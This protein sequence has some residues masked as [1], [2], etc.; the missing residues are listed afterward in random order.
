MLQRLGGKIEKLTITE[1]SRLD[2]EHFLLI[3]KQLKEK[4]L[5]IQSQIE[6]TR[7]LK[8]P[9]EERTKLS[10]LQKELIS[11]MPMMNLVRTLVKMEAL[12]R[13][14]TLDGG[15]VS[16]KPGGLSKVKQ[17]EIRVSRHS[18]TGKL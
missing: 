15:L 8:D 6:K 12:Y 10:C 3:L 4:A 1:L 16:P 9:C 11:V 17:V 18:S 5:D 13:G 2:Y 14:N 7:E